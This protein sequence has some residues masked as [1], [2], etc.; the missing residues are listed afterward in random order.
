MYVR[1][2]N[3]QTEPTFKIYVHEDYEFDSEARKEV[4]PVVVL[5]L[6]TVGI[7]LFCGCSIFWFIRYKRAQLAEYED[8][9]E[10]EEKFLELKRIR[11]QIHRTKKNPDPDDPGKLDRLNGLLAETKLRFLNEFLDL[12]EVIDYSKEENVHDIDACAI[13]T[14]DYEEGEQLTKM[15]PCSHL[16]HVECARGWFDTKNQERE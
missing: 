8:L 5:V 16:V 14:V 9:T 12:L 13:C 11:G 10:A 1:N 2:I 7:I 15:P 4:N 3:S 6:M